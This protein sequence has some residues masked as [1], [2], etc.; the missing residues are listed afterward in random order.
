[1]EEKE[2]FTITNKNGF[3]QAVKLFQQLGKENTDAVSIIKTMLPIDGS[4]NIDF[5][6]PTLFKAVGVPEHADILMKICV[7]KTGD[8]KEWLAFMLREN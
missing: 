4:A 1:M 6:L 2:N 8:G 3:L 7:V 5:K